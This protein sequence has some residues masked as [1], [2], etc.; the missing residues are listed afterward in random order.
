MI[1]RARYNEAVRAALSLYEQARIAVT[2]EEAARI[3]V[4]DFGLSDLPVIGLQLLVYVNTPRVCAKEMALL[5][6][7]TCP[8][9]LHP[10]I[11][12]QPGKEETF[13]CRWG[14]CHLFV[15]DEAC[16]TPSPLT[17][18]GY[19]EGFTAFRHIEPHPG[20]QYALC[21]GTLHWFTAGDEGAVISEFSTMSR[22]E[23]DVFTD[24]RIQ[25]ATL[26]TD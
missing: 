13:R 21:P 25:R 17:P 4:A 19:E 10:A 5:P 26:V 1:T 20:Q 24:P 12:G 11:D 14:V 8:E 15:Y 9:H 3:E 16:K 18:K 6:H 2:P 7:Q 23:Y 22:D